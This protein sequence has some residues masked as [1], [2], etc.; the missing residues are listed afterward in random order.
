MQLAGKATIMIVEAGV[1]YTGVAKTVNKSQN[2]RM[3]EAF[4]KA[5]F[6]DAASGEIIGRGGHKRVRTCSVT[7]IFYDPSTPSTLAAVKT[8]T[9]LPDKMFSVVALSDTGLSWLDGNWNYEG[10]NYDG[11]YGSSHQFTLD[12]WQKVTDAGVGSSLALV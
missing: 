7:V 1:A 5:E 3:T 4:D 11:S 2:F 12:L 6:I 10:G 9:V 8:N